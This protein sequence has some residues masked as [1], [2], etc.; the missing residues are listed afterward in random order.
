MLGRNLHLVNDNN[1]ADE[2]LFANCCVEVLNVVWVS[3]TY[4]TLYYICKE[5]FFYLLHII[6]LIYL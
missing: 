1:D 3:N 4:D 2:D 6:L 5:G